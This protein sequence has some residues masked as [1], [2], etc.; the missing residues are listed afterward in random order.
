M[1]TIS[2]SEHDFNRIRSCESPIKPQIDI[3]YDVVGNSGYNF[4][5]VTTDGQGFYHY[6]T[7]EEAILEHG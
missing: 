1:K 5:A 4:V 7:V 2:I 3:V 6:D